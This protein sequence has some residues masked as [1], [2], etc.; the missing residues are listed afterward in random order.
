MTTF[1][2]TVRKPRNDGFY[3]VYIRLVHNRKPGYIKT[4]KIVAA[5]QITSTGDI[6]DPVVNEYCAMLIRQYTDRLNRVDTTHWDIKE[7]IE[8]LLETEEDVCFSS[9]ARDFISKMQ[10]SGHARTARN[11][12][13]SVNHLERFVGSTQIYFSQLTSTVLNKWLEDLSITNRAKEQYPTCIRQIFKRALVEMNDEERGIIRI[14]FNPWMKVKIPKSDT[15]VKLAISAEACREF[16]NRPLPVSE[17][18]SPLPE[19]GRDVAL[20][21]LC[22]AGMNT[23]DMYRLKK[24]DYNN[25]IISY[26]RSKTKHFRKDEAYFEIRVEPFIKPIIEKYLADPQDEYLFNFHC[27]YNGYDS[28]NANVN[29]GIRTICYDMG[30]TKEN[31]YCFYTFRH[32]WATIAQN[33]CDA[34]LYEVAFGMNHS[35]GLNVTRGYVKIDFTPA[36]ELNAKIIDFIF[37]T[38][39]KSKQGK[40][41]GLYETGDSMFRITKRMLIQGRAYFKGKQV[42]EVNDIGFDTVDA[43][44]KRL[45][46]MLPADIPVGC[47]VHFRL[48][49]CDTQRE[50]VYERSKGK[51]F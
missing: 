22:L 6:K 42:A 4:T 37:F 48:T 12:E 43:V 45:V 9:Y 19:L 47:N 40:A 41:R 36:W 34:N 15:T 39:K 24:T 27:R 2:A 31:K 30:M 8:Y 16:F 11:Y 23:V 26:R 49:N 38:D 17:M 18:S 14:K 29:V 13:L 33:D 10:K 51:G 25:G 1:K 35:Q 20:L 50:A 28:F 46:P 44:I 32:T 3:S 21:S 7:V 5:E